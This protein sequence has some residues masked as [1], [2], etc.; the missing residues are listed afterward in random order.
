MTERNF[1]LSYLINDSRSTLNK[2][3]CLTSFCPLPIP[4]TTGSYLITSA[5]EAMEM[6]RLFLHALSRAN[7]TRLQLQTSVARAENFALF[8]L[9]WLTDFLNQS[10]ENLS[11]LETLDVDCPGVEVSGFDEWSW[12][13]TL[14]DE[15]PRTSEPSENQ[16]YQAIREVKKRGRNNLKTLLMK[17][18][19][20]SL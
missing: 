2:V 6:L 18:A 15:R 13:A 11:T 12:L 4:Y 16:F 8:P 1:A 10:S 14:N 5:A 7:I 3:D 19:L 20:K 9:T 17:G